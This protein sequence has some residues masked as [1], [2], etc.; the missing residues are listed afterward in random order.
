MFL[1]HRAQALITHGPIGAGGLAQSCW[2]CM[3]GMSGTV[4]TVPYRHPKLAAESQVMGN[5]N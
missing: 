2:W 5:T 4:L 3:A 1:P